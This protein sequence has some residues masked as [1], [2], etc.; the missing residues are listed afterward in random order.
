MSGVSGS[1]AVSFPRP[2]VQAPLGIDVRPL[3]EDEVVRA[4]QV[5]EACSEMSAERSAGVYRRQFAR[6]MGDGMLWAAFEGAEMVGVAR[7]AHF[8][9]PLLPLPKVVP[10]GWYLM[11][12]N[13]LPSHRRRGIGRSFTEQRLSWLAERT[14]VVWFFTDSQNTAS[15]RLHEEFG[16][17]EVTRDFTFPMLTFSSGQGVLFRRVTR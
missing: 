4:A 14:D 9:A 12:V 10:D 8:T 5:T 17:V 3:R 13:V 6:G 7:V 2:G 15:I 16:F 1:F 11:G